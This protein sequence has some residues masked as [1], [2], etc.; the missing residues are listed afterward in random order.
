MVAYFTLQLIRGKCQEN[1]VLTSQ[2]NG[3]EICNPFNIK[4]SSSVQKG[5]TQKGKQVPGRNVSWDTDAFY[6]SKKK[7]PLVQLPHNGV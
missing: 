6:D 1:L 4:C 7:K 5:Q 3:C 2:I